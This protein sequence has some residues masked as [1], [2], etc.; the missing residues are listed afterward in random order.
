MK[1]LIHKFSKMNKIYIL[2]LTLTSTV[3]LFAQTAL[4]GSGD[5]N[6][7]DVNGIPLDGGLSL[8]VAGAAAYGIKK[9]RENKNE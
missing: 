4:P 8:L 5:N 1:N 9:L 3:S 7:Q 6:V 2:V